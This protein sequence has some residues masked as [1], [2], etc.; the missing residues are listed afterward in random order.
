MKYGGE[1]GT[2]H[3][4]ILSFSVNITVA[5]KRKQTKNTKKSSRGVAGK[6]FSSFYSARF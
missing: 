2:T 1:K 5:I 3:S 6:F 4:H